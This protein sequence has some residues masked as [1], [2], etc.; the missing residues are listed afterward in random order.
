MG[1]L[2][3]DGK[4][5]PSTLSLSSIYYMFANLPFMVRS[6]R[7]GGAAKM[8]FTSFKTFLPMSFLRKPPLFTNDGTPRDAVVR[9]YLSLQV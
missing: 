8:P 9:N 5:S 4:N 3:F 7:F 2:L 1:Q 6:G